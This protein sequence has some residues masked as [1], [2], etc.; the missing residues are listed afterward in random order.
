MP[1]TLQSPAKINLSLEILDKRPDGYHNLDSFFLP[2]SLF[3]TL[4]FEEA[5]ELSLRISPES[6]IPVEKI[7][8]DN[9]NL[10]LRA[11]RILQRRHAPHAGAKITLSKHIP[12]GGGLGG[13]S[14][15]CATTF[16]A[17]NRLW[18]LDLSRETLEA[19]AAELGSD[20]P[21]FVQGGAVRMTGRGEILRPAF[22][23]C[24][25]NRESIPP[26]WV[27][28][29]NCGEHCSTKE[30]YKHYI[31]ELTPRPDF[32]YTVAHFASSGA[33]SQLAENLFNSLQKGVYARYPRVE[34]SARLL[35][36]AGAEGVLLSGSGATV[37]GLVRDQAHGQTVC[38]RLPTEMWKA[39]ARAIYCPMV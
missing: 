13:G 29:L 33:V 38:G 37:F 21:A 36:E 10:I 1:L 30:V 6:T 24:P 8:T 14:S 4:V 3:D 12:I 22:P 27:V 26:L 35:K 7:G 39:V 2:V 11:A 17:L 20:T 16:H 18:D 34:T 32:Y 9:D 31:K 15:N 23:D 28:L 5:P 19:Y 25:E